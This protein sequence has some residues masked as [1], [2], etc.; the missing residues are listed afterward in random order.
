MNTA[1]ADD[2]GS[3]Q[4]LLPTVS[5]TDRV[6]GWYHADAGRQTA[7]NG[8]QH[9]HPQAPD[10]DADQTSRHSSGNPSATDGPT[11]LHRPSRT[12]R[13]AVFLAELAA[14]P[15]TIGV[16]DAGRILGCGR[17]LA[18]DLVRR[19]EF[20]CRVLRL[21]TRYLVPTAD[22]LTALGIEPTAVLRVG[23]KHDADGQAAPTSP[24][25]TSP[26]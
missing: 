5:P 1:S 2:L 12:R 11:S 13:A 22:L 7:V 19:G 25:T 4:A 16:E 26:R 6:E 9:G 17:S 8:N 14:L 20:P 23:T 3:T 21:G 10:T 18:Y 24:T 15:P